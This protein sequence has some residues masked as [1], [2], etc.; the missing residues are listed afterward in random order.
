MDAQLRPEHGLVRI[1]KREMIVVQKSQPTKRTG[2]VGFESTDFD[3]L[4]NNLR[5]T[6][7][8]GGLLVLRE[9]PFP[10]KLSLMALIKPEYLYANDFA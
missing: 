2:R 3:F 10:W 6:V 8:W 5:Q 9:T 1:A 4:L 7:Q